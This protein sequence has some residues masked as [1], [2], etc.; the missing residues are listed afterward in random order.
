[1]IDQ[2]RLEHNPTRTNKYPR[3]RSLSASPTYT[4]NGDED[5][6]SWQPLLPS[7]AFRLLDDCRLTEQRSNGIHILYTV[8]VCQIRHPRRACADPHK[9]QFW[10]GI[11]PTSA[12]EDHS[13]QPLPAGGLNAKRFR[14]CAFLLCRLAAAGQLT[15]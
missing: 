6:Y 2:T 13:N 11:W 1:M 5:S 8:A 3:C 12:A 7:S 4:A 9:P 14:V 15:S 10:F